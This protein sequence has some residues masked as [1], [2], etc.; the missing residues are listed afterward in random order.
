MSMLVSRIERKDMFES[1]RRAGTA[2][3]LIS[4]FDV[5]DSLLRVRL[6]ETRRKTL[7]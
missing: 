5:R 1:K 7:G 3:L 4:G 2:S 6:S